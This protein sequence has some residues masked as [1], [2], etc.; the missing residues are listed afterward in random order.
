MAIAVATA[1]AIAAI[2][3]HSLPDYD[4][5][6]ALIWGRDIA[7]LN[8]PDYALPYRPAGHPLTTLVAL[9]GV[10]LGNDGA[11][12]L[13]RWVA[14]VGAGAFVAAVFRLGQ[15][16]FGTAAGA[17]AA[18]LLATR[19]PL[20]GFSQLAFMD[21]W[22]AALVVWAALLEV[23]A[24]R[25]GAPV[26]VLLALAGLIRPEVWLFAGAYLVWLALGDRQ[27]ALRLL[28]LAFLAPIAWGIFDL[29]TVQDFLGSVSTKEGLPTATSTGGH[30]LGRAPSA[31]ARFAGGFARPPEVF[32]AAVGL[33]LVWRMRLWRRA[34]APLAIAG[35]NVFT[36]VLVAGR[37]G[38][39]EQR[40]LLVA[41]GMVLV[42]A[43]FAIAQAVAATEPRIVRMAG[44]LLV[45]ACIAYAPIDIRRLDDLHDQV[46]TAD[47]VYSDL[48]DRVEDCD[49]SARVQVPDVRLRP[50]VAYW[51]D[52]APARVGTE[53]AAARAEP[54][55]PVATELSSRS[56]PRDPDVS[57][58]TPPFWKLA[59]CARQ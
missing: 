7:H 57:P 46:K 27:R 14:L 28:P 13:I 34:A 11:A 58:G 3:G 35:L 36:F 51:A 32:A 31:L 38:P 42:F 25:R 52:V 53:P 59:G 16:S 18:V 30:G 29:I 5:T 20:W 41:A 9:I 50:Q 43:G 23:R 17:V 48:R 47:V 22:A 56:L 4:A 33:V 37:A 55:G 54:I 21:A 40:Y 49:F 39:L 19:S 6:F 12:E 45:V 10:P 26:F 44:A 24:Q 1:L 2:G 15:A 8:A